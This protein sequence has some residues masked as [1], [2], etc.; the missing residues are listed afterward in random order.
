MTAATCPGNDRGE[1]SIQT[2]LLV[3]VILSLFFVAVHAAALS[4]AG[5]I[6]SVAANRGAQMAASSDGSSASASA[7]REGIQR[8][9]LELGSQMSSESQ[10]ST[11]SGSVEVTVRISVPR[12][13]PF[14]PNTVKRSASAP[15]EQFIEEQ[16]RR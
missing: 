5:Q 6:A 10:F 13:V 11:Y 1:T 12:V 3:P 14:L 15:L 16:N 2:V 4:H 8:T 9:V 7:I